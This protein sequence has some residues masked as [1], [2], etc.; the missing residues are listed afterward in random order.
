VEVEELQA[1]KEAV[2]SLLI[3]LRI[4]AVYPEDHAICRKSLVHVR[5]QLE[6]FFQEYG[7]LRLDVDRTGLRLR[8]EVVHD[9]PA[10]DGNPAFILFRDGIQWLEVQEQIELWEI[11]EF[12]RLMNRYR[13]LSEEAEGD[14]V[15]G[16]WEAQLPHLLHGAADLLREADVGGEISPWESPSPGSFQE[17]Q[18]VAP[19]LSHHPKP[20]LP[21][22]NAWATLTPEDEC[23]LQEMVLEE[24]TRDPTKDVLEMLLD[25]VRDDE[26][27]EGAEAALLFL[28][29]EFQNALTQGAFHVACNILQK[30]HLMRGVFEGGRRWGISLVEQFFHVASS[31]SSINAIRGHWEAIDAAQAGEIRQ[32]LLLLPPGAIASIAPLLSEAPSARL[33]RMLAEAIRTLASRDI[34]PLVRELERSDEDLLQRLVYILGQMEGERPTELLLEKT[35]HPMERVR[36][37]AVKALLIRGP[38]VL[39]RIFVLIE[40]ESEAIRR[41]F[42]ESLGWRRNDV[43]EELLLDYLEKRRCR[44]KHNEHVLACFK[45]LGRCGSAR[46]IPFLRRTLSERAWLPSFWQSARRLG[47]AV[48]LRA[49][50]IEAAARVLNEAERSPYP[51]IRHALRKAVEVLP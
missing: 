37:E 2:A 49:L 25:L 36:R 51:S 5:T 15:T 45:A 48:A 1:A 31:P 33:Q 41:L 9:G 30:A 44:I 50:R 20:P 26:E 22:D 35:R 19:E 39:R 28:E 14:L 46:S 38:Q 16:L 3:S 6:G 47:A 18:E 43:A 13:G 42:L 21:S 11:T 40:D 23:Q 27:E 29:E 10:E 34:E 8:G 17:A 7:D 4:H 24:E 32:M 12:I